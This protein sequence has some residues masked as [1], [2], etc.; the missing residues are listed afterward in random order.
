MLKIIGK[1]M[2]VHTSWVLS[3]SISSDGRR[4]V[5]SWSDGSVLAWDTESGAQICSVLYGHDKDVW[6][7]AISTDGDWAVSREEYDGAS[8]ELAGRSTI[9]QDIYWTHGCVVEGGDK[10]GQ[11]T[12][13]VMVT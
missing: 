1:A 12:D 6:S 2:T 4:T 13:C 10:R 7:V 9:K 11:E 8:L 3:V 5:C